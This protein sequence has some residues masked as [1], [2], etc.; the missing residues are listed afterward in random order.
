MAMTPWLRSVERA[1]KAIPKGQTVSYGQVAML[2]GRA[3]GARA[4]V[5]ALHL[6]EGV[7]WWRVIRSDGSIAA[8]V[9]A[10]QSRKL[11]AEGVDVKG[12]RVPASARALRRP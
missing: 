2:A 12:G 5:R 3:G 6:L 11:R 9:R 10:E 1:V 8:P 7:P 4:V